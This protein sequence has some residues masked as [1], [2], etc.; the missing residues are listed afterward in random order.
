MLL[1]VNTTGHAVDRTLTV[2][3]RELAIRFGESEGAVFAISISN[4]SINIKDVVF[5]EGS[6]SYTAGRFAGSG[7]IVFVG[8]GPL[9]LANGE[10]NPL[11]RGVLLRDATIGVIND[12]QRLRA[13]R[14]RH[15]SSS[16]ASSDVTARGHAPRPREHLRPGDRTRC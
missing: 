10:R 7:L 3:G 1:R 14:A 9:T 16:S 6:V 12:R 13:R 11:A 15:R 8:D 4:A 2:G 5:V